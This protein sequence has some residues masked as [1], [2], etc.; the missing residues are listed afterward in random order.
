M[1]RVEKAW[2]RLHD[3]RVINQKVNGAWIHDSRKHAS[4]CSFGDGRVVELTVT[5]DDGKK[6]KKRKA[7]R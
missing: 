1:K 4:E 7:K 5:Y 2:V 3:G 6:P